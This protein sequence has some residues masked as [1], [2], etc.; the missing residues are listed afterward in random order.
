MT[1][2][3]RH[4]QGSSSSSSQEFN[5]SHSVS[6]GSNNSSD[7]AS[8]SRGPV[9]P[10]TTNGNSNAPSIPDLGLARPAYAVE[11]GGPSP[12]L[13]PSAFSSETLVQSQQADSFPGL[14]G[15]ATPAELPSPPYPG[16]TA[17]YDS[18]VSAASTPRVRC[19]IVP[20]FPDFLAF[21]QRVLIF[22]SPS[23]CVSPFFLPNRNVNHAVRFIP[24]STKATPAYPTFS[25]RRPPPA[26]PRNGSRK[27]NPSSTSTTAT[28]STFGTAGSASSSGSSRSSSSPTRRST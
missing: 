19:Q 17:L 14:L 26:C 25:T 6:S 15:R 23:P 8:S 1:G 7:R 10:E 22:A 3:Q 11:D 9:L 21:V 2:R 18:S 4:Q 16:K 20:I 28:T 5:I 13:L 24:R 12:T 27:K